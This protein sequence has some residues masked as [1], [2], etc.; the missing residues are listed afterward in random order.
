MFEDDKYV[1]STVAAVSKEKCVLG[2]QFN[3]LQKTN[4]GRTPDCGILKVT[5]YKG[6]SYLS[7]GLN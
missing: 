7:R 3:F 1:W 5:I 2:D 4:L 6:Y